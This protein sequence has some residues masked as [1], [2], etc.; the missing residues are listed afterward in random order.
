MK[1]EG[2][3]AGY[4]KQIVDYLPSEL[5]FSSE[6]NKDWYKATDG[7]I[8]TKALAD[9]IIN[10]GETKEIKLVA[11]KATTENNLGTTNNS[12]EI[13]ESYNEYGVADTDSTTGNNKTKEDDY[14]SADIL[15]TLNTGT[16]IMYISLTISVI[17]IIGI[18]AYMIKKKVLGEM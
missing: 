10:P 17:A 18:G 14:G 12:A 13:Y 3:I 11:T 2:N 4:A 6:L 5:K 16:I 15:I 8:Y 1:N 7:K 9:T